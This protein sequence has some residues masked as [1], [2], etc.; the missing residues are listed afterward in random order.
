MGRRR[1][2]WVGGSAGVAAASLTVSVST[3]PRWNRARTKPGRSVLVGHHSFSS[4]GAAFWKAGLRDPLAVRCAVLNE[5][6]RYYPGDSKQTSSCDN[7]VAPDGGRASCGNCRLEREQ[8]RGIWGGL[9]LLT[10]FRSCLKTFFT[11]VIIACY[12]QL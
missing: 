11:W 7:K 8:L 12:G 5:W 9:V 10:H 6:L 4:C 2:S 3:C 1:V